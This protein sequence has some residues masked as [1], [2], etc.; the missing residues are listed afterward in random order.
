MSTDLTGLC[1]EHSFET[2]A[3]LCQRCGLE[4]CDRCVV[5]PFGPKKPLCKDCALVTSG[6]RS[7]TGRQAMPPRLVKKR[8]RAFA[9]IGVVVAETTHAPT[10]PPETEKIAPPPPAEPR[11]ATGVA[12]GAATTAPDVDGP[13]AIDWSQPF[14]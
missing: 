7:Q 6:V 4:Y 8:A 11:P 2:A 1:R 10:G 14:G 13:T 9:A 5:Y 12:V 3:A